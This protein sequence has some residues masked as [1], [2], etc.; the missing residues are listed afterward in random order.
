MAM[1]VLSLRLFPSLQTKDR[2][3]METDETMPISYFQ[4]RQQTPCST[5]TSNKNLK[6][7]QPYANSV[8]L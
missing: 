8:W 6:C 2:E 3:E 5:E 4:E 7:R 1:A